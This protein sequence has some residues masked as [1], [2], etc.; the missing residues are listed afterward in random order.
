MIDAPRT[1]Y[2]VDVE[3]DQTPCVDVAEEGN[4]GCCKDA[5]GG[6]RKRCEELKYHIEVI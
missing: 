4:G 1:Q 5:G 2:A 6:H 3:I